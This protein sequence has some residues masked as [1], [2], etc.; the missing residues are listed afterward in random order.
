MGIVREGRG[1]NGY[2]KVTLNAILYVDIRRADSAA[3]RNK[4]D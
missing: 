1:Q 3:Q 2:G 4:R